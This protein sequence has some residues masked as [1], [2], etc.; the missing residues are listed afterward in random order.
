VARVE[1]SVLEVDTDR[2]L[3]EARRIAGGRP[4]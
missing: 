1:A 3:E 2:D 4:E